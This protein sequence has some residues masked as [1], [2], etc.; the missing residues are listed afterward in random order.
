[1]KTSPF[2]KPFEKVSF[3]YESLFPK[4]PGRYLDIASTRHIAAYSPPLKIKS[5]IDIS[6]STYL[7]IIL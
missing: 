5:P 7:S 3:K 4:V 1:M 2:N 6:S